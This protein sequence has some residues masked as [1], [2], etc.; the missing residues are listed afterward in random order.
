MFATVLRLLLRLIGRLLPAWRNQG[1]REPTER[2]RVH[3]QHHPP[4]LECPARLAHP[5]CLAHP[6]RRR[7]RQV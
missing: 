7:E 5:E 4:H 3:R 6:A 2:R 1:R